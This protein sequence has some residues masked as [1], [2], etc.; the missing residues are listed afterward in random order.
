[1]LKSLSIFL[2]YGKSIPV[3]NEKG[4]KRNMEK[5][6]LVIIGWQ[7]GE[8]EESVM[9]YRRSIEVYRRSPGDQFRTKNEKQGGHTRSFL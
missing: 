6:K 9:V 7:V 4:S 2:Y 5:E 1:M 8:V 3:R